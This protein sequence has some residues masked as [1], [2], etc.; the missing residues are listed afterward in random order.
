MA[1]APAIHRLRVYLQFSRQ[2]TR[3]GMESIA[4]LRDQLVELTRFVPASIVQDFESCS[5]VIIKITK[6]LYAFK[7]RGF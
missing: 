1:R 4:I 7:T 3:F 2:I 6:S 5:D